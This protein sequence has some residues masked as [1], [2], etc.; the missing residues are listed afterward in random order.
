MK[1][2]K[3]TRGKSFFDIIPDGSSQINISYNYPGTIKAFHLHKKQTDYF[4]C[5]SG[6][7]KLVLT[8]PEEVFYMSQGDI[9]EIKPNRWHGFQVLGQEVAIML[10]YATQKYAP[11]D[12]EREFWQKF[13]IWDIEKK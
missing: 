12:E 6:E 5:I 7:I 4:F 9:Q 13:D 3:D 1:T 10:E 8:N 2:F 11:A